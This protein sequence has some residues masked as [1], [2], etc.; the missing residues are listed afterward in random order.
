MQKEKQIVKIDSY[1]F[2]GY[3]IPGLMIFLSGF[4]AA[5]QVTDLCAPEAAIRI[6]QKT[7][8]EAGTAIF[9]SVVAL[10]VLGSYLAGHLSSSISSFFFDKLLVRNVL[11]YP[12]R[13]L[14]F[15]EG[16]EMNYRGFVYMSYISFTLL[17][18]F[19][20][21]FGLNVVL[22]SITIDYTLMAK[23]LLALVL[24]QAINGQVYRRA[25]EH[26]SRSTTRFLAHIYRLCSSPFLLAEYVATRF[27]GLTKTFPNSVNK[28]IQDRYLAVFGDELKAEL[29]SEAYWAIYWYVTTSNQYLRSKI[30][31]WL[32]LYGFMRNSSCA[33]LLSS[34]IIALPV[35]SWGIV[36]PLE[37]LA[38]EALFVVG[39]IYSFRY[40]YLYFGYYSKT[41]FRVFAFLDLENNDQASE[42]AG[43]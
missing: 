36:S 15:N 28:R 31:K 23:I 30:D 34:V 32:V 35:R 24:L 20:Y 26:V 12:F 19:A 39:L 43:K 11:G 41:I 9:S 2:F 27:L 42:D 6:I 14:L 7:L 25:P 5:Q 4:L 40:Y 8:A 33:V 3:L 18:L 21:V 22:Y 17:L 10:T 1:D 16:M 29:A 38:A 13:S 37:A